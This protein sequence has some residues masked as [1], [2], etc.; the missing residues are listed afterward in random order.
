MRAMLARFGL[1]LATA[2]VSVCWA[3]LPTPTITGLDSSVVGGSPGSSPVTAITS[4]S[5]PAGGFTLYI[6]GAF[7]PRS[8]A[9]VTWAPA[10]GTPTVFTNT[11]APT[12]TASFTQLSLTIPAT[13]YQTLVSSQ[14]AVTVTVAELTGVSNGATFTINPPLQSLGP[15][16]PVAT[17]NQAYPDTPYVTGGTGPYLVRT[18]TPSLAPGL[19]FDSAQT[20]ILGTP[21]ATGGYNFQVT[22]FD[23]WGNTLTTSLP[24]Y[25]VAVPTLAST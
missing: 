5:I 24:I 4:G 14:V 15:V 2:A 3:Q 16:L 20:G 21:T 9:N 10:G 1:L 18:V 8:F 6:N 25:V 12:V 19:N 23:I 22:M 17:L 11:F 13:L 7:S